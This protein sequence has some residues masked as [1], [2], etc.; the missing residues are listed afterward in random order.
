[1]ASSRAA[2]GEGTFKLVVLQQVLKLVPNGLNVLLDEYAIA[3][4]NEIGL[5]TRVQVGVDA[6]YFFC[7]AR[8]DLP[9]IRGAY[10]EARCCAFFM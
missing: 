9:R 10:Y 5:T 7:Q 6:L 1:M 3:L 2:T 8:L 4:A